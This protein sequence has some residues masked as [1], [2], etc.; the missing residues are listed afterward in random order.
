VQFCESYCDFTYKDKVVLAR[1]STV[2]YLKHGAAICFYQNF[3]N[4]AMLIFIIRKCSYSTSVSN[5]Q[6]IFITDKGFR[7]GKFGTCVVKFEIAKNFW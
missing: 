4:S 7:Y 6:H 3:V 1:C 2:V 5:V